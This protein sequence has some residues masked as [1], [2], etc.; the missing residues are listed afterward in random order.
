MREILSREHKGRWSNLR[1]RNNAE[2]VEEGFTED[3]AK[4]TGFDKLN[5]KGSGTVTCCMSQKLSHPGEKMVKYPKKLT[6]NTTNVFQD[7]NSRR[8]TS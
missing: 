8:I 7:E 2:E 1:S 5:I 6:T 4:E 3:S